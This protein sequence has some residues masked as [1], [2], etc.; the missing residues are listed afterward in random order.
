MQRRGLVFEPYYSSGIAVLS[1][2][3]LPRASSEIIEENTGGTKEERICL[4]VYLGNSG[5]LSKERK[6]VVIHKRAP[7][8]VVNSLYRTNVLVSSGEKSWL[9]E[10]LKFWGGSVEVRTDD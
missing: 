7:T 5:I 9:I 2:S 4:Y 10:F 8:Y 1:G 6:K 3:T